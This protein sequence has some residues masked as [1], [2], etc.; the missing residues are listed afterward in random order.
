MTWPTL[1]ALISV[2]FLPAS[3]RADDWPQFRGPTG[4]GISTAKNLPLHWSTTNNIAWKAAIPGRGRSSPVILGDRIW[5]TTAIEINP[6]KRIEGSDPVIEVDRAELGLVCF[7]RSNG[8]QLFHVTLFSV[9][10]PPVAHELNSYATPTPV[11][12]AGH[13]YCDFG[14]FGTACV[15]GDTGKV[16]W[17]NRL[18]LDHQIG[19]G[20]SPV[21]W[22]NLMIVVRDGRDRQ[23]VAALDKE[24]GK[25][26]WQTDRPPIIAGS[27]N[28]KKSFSTPIIAEFNGRSQVIVPCAHWLVSYEPETGRELWRLKHGTGFSIG[29][30]PVA[31]KDLVYFLTGMNRQLWAVRPDGSGEVTKTQVAWKSPAQM[32]TMPSPLLV[33]QEIYALSDQGLLFCLDA[34]TGE[35][36][37]RR[38]TG[39]P[40][41]SS[42]L[43]ADGRIY[44]F[45]Q[46]GKGVVLKAGKNLEVLAEN[47]LEG[48]LFAV[49]AALQDGLY[50]RT[51]SHLYCI[52]ELGSQRP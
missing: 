51:D 37:G 23:F 8:K 40:T 3:L 20:S 9:T 15:E 44:V 10:N 24:T 5:L 47:Q 18:P 38:G 2:L 13:I 41:A 49:P 7:Q 28:L 31:G 17:E 12:E 48:P 43:F 27:G 26:A 34:A 29:P 25:L 4:D 36:L 21:L 35:E 14:T 52:R 50:V 30:R 11:A 22:K 6:R 46:K 19:P 33:G 45:S 1:L 32:G 42:P 16:I 39:G